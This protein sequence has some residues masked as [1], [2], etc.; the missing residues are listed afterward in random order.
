MSPP[1]VNMDV[2]DAD[3]HVVETERVW[4]YLDASDEKYRPTLTASPENPRRRYVSPKSMARS[5]S[6]CGRSSANG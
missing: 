4:D 6:A 2:I 5:A 3:A 1:R